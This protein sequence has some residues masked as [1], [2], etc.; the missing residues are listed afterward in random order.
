MSSVSP[1]S[2]KPKLKAYAVLALFLLMLG[3]ALLAHHEKMD[4]VDTDQGKRSDFAALGPFRQDR[5]LVSRKTDSRCPS[6]RCSAH[7][8]HGGRS[9]LRNPNREHR[10]ARPAA[11]L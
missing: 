11:S 2:G 7:R 3:T 10:S 9:H 5:R 4:N 8:A 6:S 1:A